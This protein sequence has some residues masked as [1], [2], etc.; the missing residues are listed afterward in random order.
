MLEGMFGRV[1]KAQWGSI[2]GGMEP[3]RAGKLER[4]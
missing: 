1:L 2:K 3:K 4:R